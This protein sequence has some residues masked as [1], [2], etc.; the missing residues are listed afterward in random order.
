MFF[1]FIFIIILISTIAIYT[2]R[3]GIEIE[4]LIIDTEKPKGNKINKDSKIFVY[5]LVF[6]KIKLFKKDVK[7]QKIKFRNT[8]I[9]L[10]LLKSKDLKIDYKQLLQKPDIYIDQINLNV[11]IGT[12][13]AALTAI[14]TG[15]IGGIL[16][17]VLQRPK[18]EIIP[19]YANRNFLKIKLDCIISIH[20]M[21]YIYKLV[22]KK[23]KDLGTEN[24]NKKVEV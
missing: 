12:Q 11:Q 19:I 18:F 10:K 22:A 6:K 20:L 5:I 3:L 24:L 8:E 2:S 1:L 16:G 7:N 23:I 4:N 9:D 13:D 17:G 21:Q 14:L 15:I